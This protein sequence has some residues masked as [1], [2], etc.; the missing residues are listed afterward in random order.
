MSVLSTS[1]VNGTVPDSS[2]FA[3]LMFPPIPSKIFSVALYSKPY[4]KA[5]PTAL[6]D[7]SCASHATLTDDTPA[8]K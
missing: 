6:A 8:P 2:G 4:L 1:A 3:V 7:V 5:N